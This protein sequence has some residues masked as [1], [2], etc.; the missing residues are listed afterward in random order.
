MLILITSF[1]LPD[2]SALSLI[3]FTATSLDV[4]VLSSGVVKG[5]VLRQ[6]NPT[7]LS[8]QEKTPLTLVTS[9]GLDV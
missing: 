5:M 4:T 6:D 8:L 3:Q 1:C 9:L 7:F 2:S